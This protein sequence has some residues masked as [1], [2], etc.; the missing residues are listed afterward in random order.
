MQNDLIDVFNTSFAL[1][2]MVGVVLSVLGFFIDPLLE[3]IFLIVLVLTA[4]D[5]TLGYTRA[6]ADKRHVVS[7]VMK[8]YMWKFVGYSVAMSSL[9]LM[10]NAMPPDVAPLTGWLDNF[11]LAFFAVHE[12][13]SIVEHLNEIGVPLPTRLLGN[14]RKIKQATDGEDTTD[15][16]FKRDV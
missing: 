11:A 12:T 10:S 3:K 16:Y 6:F 5:C 7:F 15:R 2:V 1:K 8:R 13:I 14:L 4:I 9:Y